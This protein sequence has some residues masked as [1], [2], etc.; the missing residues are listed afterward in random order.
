MLRGAACYPYSLFLYIKAVWVF[1]IVM[2][3][4][5]MISLVQLKI[6]WARTK[7]WHPHRIKY[8]QKWKHLPNLPDCPHPVRWLKTGGIYSLTVLRAEVQRQYVSKAVPLWRLPGKLCTSRE[9][10]SCW[11]LLTSLTCSCLNP[12]STPPSYDLLLHLSL[13]VFCYVISVCI[14]LIKTGMVVHI[15]N[16]RT[17]EAKVR[18]SHTQGQPDPYRKRLDLEPTQVIRDDLISKSFSKL[19]FET[20]AR[21]PK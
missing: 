6:A 2:L 1:K 15:C 17:H 13:F 16:P 4:E 8:T 19:R 14:T 18:G 5:E 12:V 21:T 7:G 9:I 3:K 20:F 11:Y 10:G